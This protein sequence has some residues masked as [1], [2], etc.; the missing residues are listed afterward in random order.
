MK[1]KQKRP[2]KWR[3]EFKYSI[4]QA[5]DQIVSSR[6]R[7]LFPH[8]PHAKADGSY[9]VNSLYFDTPNDKGLRQ[10]IDGVSER[11]KFRIRYYNDDLSFIRLEKKVKKARMNAK[12]SSPL[13]KEEV[14]A[15]LQ[16]EMGFLLTSNDELKIEFY[17][18]L[19]GQLL[20]PKTIV[21]Y[22][23]EA[24]LFG[25]GNVRVTI[26]RNLKTTLN[27]AHFLNPYTKLMDVEREFTIF[28]VKYDEFLPE[29]VKM[30]V[31]IPNR[32][33][34]ENSKYALSRRFD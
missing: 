10:K 29:I 9:R 17:S 19:K 25:P 13:T 6:L 8:D 7:Q 24:F 3:H 16:G 28:E 12:F 22:D 5:D 26:D 14:A 21:S 23:R 30:A 4:N 32:R 1:I 18:K 2:L 11:E 20:E 31:Q 27:P 15:V 34:R 33:A